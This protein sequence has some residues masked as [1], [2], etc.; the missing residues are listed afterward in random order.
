MRRRSG[1][2]TFGAVWPADALTDRGVP[3]FGA[4]GPQDLSGLVDTIPIERPAIDVDDAF[5]V[6]EVSL[7]IVVGSA[8]DLRHVCHGHHLPLSIARTGNPNRSGSV[9]VAEPS[10]THIQL[11]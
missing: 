6:S 1:R 11:R 7:V 2:T 3:V 5:Q 9:H 10:G 4:I 8:L